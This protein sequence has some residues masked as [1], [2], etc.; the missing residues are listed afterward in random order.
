MGKKKKR[1]VFLLDNGHGGMID[2]V[3]TT[4]PNYNPALRATWRKCF[5][6]PDG[7]EI[8]EGVFNRQ[9]VNKLYDL[10]EKQGLT[11]VKIHPENE[12]LALAI[13]VER[14]N[15]EYDKAK[16]ASKEAIFISVHGNGGGGTGLEIF[17]S[18]EETSS[19]KI[20]TKFAIAMMNEFPDKKFRSDTTDGDLDKEARF[21]V[22]TG[23]KGPAILT[24]NFFM[25]RLEDC[26]FMLSEEGQDR[27]V[28][29][30]FA[31]IKEIEKNGYI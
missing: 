13:R 12:D 20:A 22:L 24:E 25:D 30:H 28:K 7:T 5:H 31:A 29:A 26:K 8:F 10:I 21:K 27:I 17:T 14:A 4:A 1:Y 6:H 9:I 2:G 15:Q 19:D 18:P 11:A 23:T 16:K 3:Y